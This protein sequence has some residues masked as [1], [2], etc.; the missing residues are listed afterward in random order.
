MIARHTRNG[1]EEPSRLPEIKCICGS[2]SR[3]PDNL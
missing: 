3:K 2:G 1:M